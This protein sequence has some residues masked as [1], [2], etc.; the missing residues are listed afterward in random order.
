MSFNNVEKNEEVRPTVEG[1]AMKK[2]WFQCSPCGF[3]NL[4][5]I[6]WVLP[7]PLLKVFFMVSRHFQTQ[8]LKTIHFLT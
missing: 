8:I 4:P 5:E 6:F 1:K 2:K 7:T 3:Y